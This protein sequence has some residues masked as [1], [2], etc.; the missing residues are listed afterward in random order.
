MGP[1]SQVGS[2]L[3]GMQVL[4]ERPDELQRPALQTALRGVYLYVTD[5]GKG[6]GCGLGS[7]GNINHQI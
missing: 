1:W 6:R 3:L 5:A 2:T 7:Q 4:G